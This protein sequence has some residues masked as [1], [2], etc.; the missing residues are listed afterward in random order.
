M[1]RV[2]T[3]G[4]ENYPNSQIKPEASLQRIVETNDK[5]EVHKISGKFQLFLGIKNP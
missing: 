4:T 1:C 2:Q 3:S 5:S